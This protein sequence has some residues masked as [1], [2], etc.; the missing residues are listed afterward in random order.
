MDI[1]YYIVVTFQ[2]NIAMLL[3]TIHLGD[4]GEFQKFKHRDLKMI[5][6]LISMLKFIFA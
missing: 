4:I 6:Q 1:L 5:Q 3:S 2:E